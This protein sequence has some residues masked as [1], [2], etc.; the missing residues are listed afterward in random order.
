MAAEEE[1]NAMKAEEETEK[2]NNEAEDQLGFFT[3]E[4]I[5]SQL[6]YWTLILFHVL[7]CVLFGV[8]SVV[9]SFLLLT[10]VV[11]GLPSILFINL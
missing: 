2:E 1:E 9:F 6:C 8:L 7:G 10:F 4:S 5:L 11:C 3:L